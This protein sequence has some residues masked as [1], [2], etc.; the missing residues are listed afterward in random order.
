MEQDPPPDAGKDGSPMQVLAVALTAVLI[1]VSVVGIVGGFA[2]LARR[3]L[4]MDRGGLL[5]QML[6]T[7]LAPRVLVLIFRP[8]R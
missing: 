1:L 8:D 6:L 3:L 7:I 2:L 5:H 4:A